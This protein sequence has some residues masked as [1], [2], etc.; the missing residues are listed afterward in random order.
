MKSKLNDLSDNR[1]T[2]RNSSWRFNIWFIAAYFL[3]L[4]IYIAGWEMSIVDFA[5]FKVDGLAV[6]SWSIAFSYG[7]VIKYHVILEF[8]ICEPYRLKIPF[9]CRICP[10]NKF[11]FTWNYSRRTTYSNISREFLII[12]C[13]NN[14]PGGF[15][16]TIAEMELLQMTSTLKFEQA[17]TKTTY[18]VAASR[19]SILH[20]GESALSMIQ[21][22]LLWSPK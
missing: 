7:S 21:A 10:W 8:Q 2:I 1:G 16:Q 18:F 4:R 5:R 15:I 20:S 6:S 13:M 3:I 14:L 12:I 22:T 17:R 19:P 9:N 11:Q